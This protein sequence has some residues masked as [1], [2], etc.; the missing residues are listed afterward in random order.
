MKESL[1]ANSKTY[2]QESSFMLHQ[3]KLHR[4]PFDMIKS[5]E[6]TIELRLYDEKRRAISVGDEIEFTRSGG[7]EKLVCKVIALYV[8]ESFA[9]LYDNLPLLKCGYTEKDISTA[10][11]DD[12][13]AYYSKEEQSKYGVLGIELALM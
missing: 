7:E 8:F 6:K 4:E 2:T 10:S 9:E 11:P 12:M 1:L 5:G 3:M 13:N